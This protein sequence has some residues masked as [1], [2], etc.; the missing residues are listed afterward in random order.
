[1]TVKLEAPYPSIQVISFLPNPVFNDSE[2][3]T[4]EIQK[5]YTMDGRLYTYIK[6]TN[7]RRKLLMQFNLHRM[8]GLELRA[9]IRAFYSTKIRLTDHLGVRWIG[10]FTVN[11]FDFS[12][13]S[14]ELQDI[15]LEFEGV[16]E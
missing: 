2:A 12:T 1:M 13:G 9:F 8:K 14:G 15:Q 11:P 10:Y 3:C 6:Q 16:K 4:N 7:G 5:H